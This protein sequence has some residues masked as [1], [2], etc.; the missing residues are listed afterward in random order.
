MLQSPNNNGRRVN[1]NNDVWFDIQN[2][3][4]VPDTENY[5]P[6]TKGML[7][8]KGSRERGGMSEYARNHYVNN[9]AKYWD[10]FFKVNQDK[11]FKN[12]QWMLREY[13]QLTQAIERNEQFNFCEIGC[14]CGNTI[15]GI[16]A[17]LHSV[18]P[19]FNP[20][21]QM[22]I[23]GFDCSEHAVKIL[24][25]QYRD[26]PNVHFFVNDLLSAEG[27]VLTPQMAE[28]M[29]QDE[30][31]KR[32]LPPKPRSINYSSMIFV[33]S[34]LSSLE[35]MKRIIN[36]KIYELLAQNGILFFRDYAVNDLAHYRYLNEKDV[37]TKQ[38]SEECF[39]RG[40]GTLVYF[41][42]IDSLKS[43]FDEDKFEIITCEYVDKVVENKG[44]GLTMNRK[45]IQL[46]CRAK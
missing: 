27:A 36:T 22:E 34:A 39:V 42:S 37:Y 25:E 16:L 8:R 1:W 44:E 3:P 32:H 6:Y 26:S 14:G 17:N 13:V 35:D 28:N 12:R 4:F 46:I 9:I 2:L 23:Y 30:F 45:F 7:H 19:Q 24:R 40:D 18:N 15:N 29:P 21:S 5:F 31:L 38:L 11:F 20:T 41:F 10:K 43:L 33:L